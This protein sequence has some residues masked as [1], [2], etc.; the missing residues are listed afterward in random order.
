M[1]YDS[2]LDV[3]E[4]RCSPVDRL[5]ENCLGYDRDQKCQVCQLGYRI[6]GQGEACMQNNDRNCLV[7]N[8]RECEV[9]VYFFH[10]FKFYFNLCFFGIF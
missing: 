4:K 2:Y 1:C 7:E 6:S 3:N 8:S 10:F 9:S 5:I